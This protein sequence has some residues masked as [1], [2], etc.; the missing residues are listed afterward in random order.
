MFRENRERQSAVGEQQQIHAYRENG[1]IIIICHIKSP[2]KLPQ[3][4]INYIISQLLSYIL[5]NCRKKPCPY[6]HNYIM[7][8]PFNGHINI[9]DLTNNY[10]ILLLVF[11]DPNI[12]E[13]TE[14]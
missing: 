6:Q 14:F 3:L 13:L 7:S 9:F 5:W 1:V 4:L 8:N 2:K 11:I 12:L 10:A